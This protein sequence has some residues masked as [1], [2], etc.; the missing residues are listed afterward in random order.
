MVLAY[1]GA[2]AYLGHYWE[3]K[4]SYI[5]AIFSSLPWALACP[6]V[7]IHSTRMRNWASSTISCHLA[8]IPPKTKI[9]F[10][11]TMRL[12]SQGLH[13]YS[14]LKCTFIN[15]FQPCA[16]LHSHHLDSG[17]SHVDHRIP[18][19]QKGEFMLVSHCVNE[20]LPSLR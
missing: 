19:L 14:N 6:S 13:T 17:L 16:A 15:S 18:Y 8:L 12:P 3:Y 5:E 11:P 10:E 20:L 4:G 9:H 7:P 2:M 1:W